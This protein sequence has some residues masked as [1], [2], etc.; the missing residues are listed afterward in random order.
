MVRFSRCVSR[1]QPSSPRDPSKHL[2]PAPF[3]P[4]IC[5][6]Y[7]QIQGVPTWAQLDVIVPLPTFWLQDPSFSAYPSLA[8]L[9]RPYAQ[10]YVPTSTDGAWFSASLVP[11]SPRRK[12][13][14]L[15]VEERPN[16]ISPKARDHGTFGRRTKAVAANPLGLIFSQVL[17]QLPPNMAGCFEETV[18]VP[19][20]SLSNHM[21]LHYRI[22]ATVR[23]V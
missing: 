14:A 18:T 15:A 10:G 19:E 3:P 22:F 21:Y 1:Y 23:A 5:S 12:T 11:P 13:G 17:V 6:S 16:P 20:P 8:V 2:D 9:I 7:W 4:L